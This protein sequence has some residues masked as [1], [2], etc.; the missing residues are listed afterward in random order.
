[1]IGQY[2]CIVVARNTRIGTIEAARFDKDHASFLFHQ[3]SRIAFRLPDI[4]LRDSEFEECQRPT[5]EQVT[6]INDLSIQ[7][8]SVEL[9]RTPCL[10]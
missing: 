3:D 10:T 8:E 7:D 2:V 6:R 1:M 9:R 4:W 5:D